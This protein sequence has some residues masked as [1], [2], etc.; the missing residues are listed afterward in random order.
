MLDTSR[1]GGSALKVL[2]SQRAIDAEGGAGAFR[3]RYDHQL[4]ILDDV[5]GHEHARNTSRLVLAALD[6]TVASELTSERLCQLRLTAGRRIEE[7]RSPFES[8]TA[9]E[10]NLSQ[11]SARA[12]QALD[13]LLNNWNSVSLQVSF[14]SVREPCC[15]IR[16]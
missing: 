9:A 13:T 12:F 14:L 2:A 16:A 15:T 6:A 3:C 1:T 7:E 10:D 4:H 8:P 11:L 5:A